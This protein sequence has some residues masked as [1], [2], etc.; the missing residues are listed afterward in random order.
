MCRWP[1]FGLFIL[2]TMV[3]C[4]PAP[5]GAGTSA[6]AAV[7]GQETIALTDEDR[8]LIAQQKVCPVGG[9]PLGDHGEPLKVMVGNRAVFICCEG[10]R[11]PLL[12]DPEKHLATLPAPASAPAPA[13]ES[14][15]PPATE[16]KTPAPEAPPTPIKES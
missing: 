4:T 1:A 14:P 11:Q 16:E 12:D 2:W 9:T 10:C 6:P 3:G 5:P 8:Q 13:V 15:A 7:T